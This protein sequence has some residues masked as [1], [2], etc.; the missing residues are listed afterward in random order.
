MP[1]FLARIVA[2]WQLEPTCKL[3]RLQSTFGVSEKR[4]AVTPKHIF[5]VPVWS[6]TAGDPSLPVPTRR[7]HGQLTSHEVFELQWGSSEVIPIDKHLRT[8]DY[9]VSPY[10]RGKPHRSG[11]RAVQHRIPDGDVDCL[12]CRPLSP[13]LTILRWRAHRW[14]SNVLTVFTPGNFS[15]AVPR[16]FL[17][18]W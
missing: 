5:Q 3:S 2:L 14:L 10:N 8:T 6:G 16:T 15:S 9:H 17:G 11:H 1:L 18:V 7:P 4:A 13:T 12:I